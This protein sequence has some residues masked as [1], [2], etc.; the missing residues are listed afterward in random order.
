MEEK[1]CVA[2]E[3]YNSGV[4][5]TVI[6]S[7]GGVSGAAFRA[8]ARVQSCELTFGCDL[9][10]GADGGSADGSVTAPDAGRLCA[11]GRKIACGCEGGTGTKVCSASVLRAHLR[12]RN[13]SIFAS[14]E[15][16]CG[17]Q[18]SE[19]SIAAA[20]KEY[21]ETEVDTG[22]VNGDRDG[23]PSAL[24]LAQ[25]IHD[26]L[27]RI[28][29]RRHEVRPGTLLNRAGARTEGVELDRRIEPLV[30]EER[31][32]CSIGRHRHRTFA[33]RCAS[34]VL[35]G[36]RTHYEGQ[37]IARH[38]VMNEN[39]RRPGWNQTTSVMACRL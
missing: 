1:N 26:D 16:G 38:A 18:H 33:V 22:A 20:G 12:L 24:H 31:A 21:W 15:Y 30:R 17:T 28:E 8:G 9:P 5:R 37:Q 2:T 25:T 35:L 6:D 7:F 19:P 11:P 23:M 34:R 32:P 3:C 27:T 14:H 29:A 10:C 13:V 39:P 4:C 36:V